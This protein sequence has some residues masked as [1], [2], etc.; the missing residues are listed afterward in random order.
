MLQVLLAGHLNIPESRVR[1]VCG[2]VGG[3]FGVKVHVYPDEVA[4]AA[5]AK[6][7]ERPVKFTSDRMEAFI[8]DIHARDHEATGRM[9]LDESGKILGFD[10]DDWTGI[11]P[12][13]IYPRTSAVEGLQVTNLIGG[14]Y[15]FDH[16]RCRT[17]VV[18]QNKGICAQYRA[19]G[20]PVAVAITEGLVDKA[21]SE[22]GID[23]IAFRR[24]NQIGRAHV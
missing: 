19:V 10:V 22:M 7:M 24:R 12:Y 18:F 15:A 2:D 8:G 9:A 4:T 23:P 1:V 16:Y 20:H 3:S 11:G 17:S 13:S 14:P 6:I 5:I 21:A